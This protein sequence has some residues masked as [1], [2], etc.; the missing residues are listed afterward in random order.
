MFFKY[1]ICSG[2]LHAELYV[3]AA[4]PEIPL[5]AVNPDDPRFVVWATSCGESV[6]LDGKKAASAGTA[7]IGSD[8]AMTIRCSNALG[9]VE[10]TILVAD[11]DHVRSFSRT[12]RQRGNSA[13]VRVEWSVSGA[14]T[15]EPFFADDSWRA[16]PPGAEGSWEG[17]VTCKGTHNRARL[18]FI[19][20]GTSL[21]VVL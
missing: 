2:A 15:V 13:T 14:E 21:R 5:F 6:M 9:T 10:K 8:R 11:R 18:D 1:S 17:I 20:G 4:P 16:L 12:L 7:P 19:A 3:Y